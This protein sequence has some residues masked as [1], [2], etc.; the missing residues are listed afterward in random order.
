MRTPTDNSLMNAPPNFQIHALDHVQ[1]AMPAGREDA[2]RAF[3][4]GLLGLTEVPK[5][6]NLARRG[7]VWFERGLLRV[8]LG[9]E[10]DFRPA[11]KAHPAFLVRDLP[12]LVR[13]LENA[14][15]AVVSDEPLEGYDRI[16]VADP[17][18]NRIELLEPVTTR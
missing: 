15:V 12:A 3:Y 1:L 14:G 9:V 6:A 5:P 10:Q 16:Y 7:G 13:H 8:H 4:A 11:R 18:G 2:A 17:F